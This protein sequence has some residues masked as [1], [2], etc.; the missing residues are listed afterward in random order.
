MAART[1]ITIPAM[2]PPL[3]PFDVEWLTIGRVLPL[4]V[5]GATKVWVVVAETSVVAEPL[6][7][8]RGAEKLLVAADVA[9]AAVAVFVYIVV[10][11]V[12]HPAPTQDWVLA[13]Q[14][15]P[16]DCCPRLAVHTAGSVVPPLFAGVVS[17]GCHDEV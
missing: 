12:H 10:A 17:A 16:H 15:G 9:D 13:Q 6:V 11:A 8:R 3:S 14:M 7:G 5:A 1:P 4:A 2:S